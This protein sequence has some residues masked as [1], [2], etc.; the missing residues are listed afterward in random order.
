MFIGIGAAV[1]LAGSA[2]A[3]SLKK[4]PEESES[5]EAESP[6]EDFDNGEIK[7]EETKEETSEETS[8]ETKEEVSEES[9][10]TEEEA[11]EDK[12]EEE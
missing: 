2:A 6:A 3:V 11:S 4:S 8:E 1:V 12:K 5:N 10:E 9:E 7:S